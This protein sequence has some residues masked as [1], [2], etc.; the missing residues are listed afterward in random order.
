MKIYK[1]YIIAIFLSFWIQATLF[2]E[3]AGHGKHPRKSEFIY[4]DSKKLDWNDFRKSPPNG[5]AYAAMTSSAIDMQ[6]EGEGNT[7]YFTINAVF[8]PGDSW[9]VPEVTA[10]ILKHEQ[11]HFDITEIWARMLRKKISSHKFKNVKSISSEVQNM[12]NWSVSKWKKM[13]TKYDHLTQH[14]IKE[15]K[16][17]KWNE[18]IRKVLVKLRPYQQS[19][20]KITLNNIK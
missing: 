7:L 11:G 18:K 6:F 13:Q 15:S 1:R 3:S 20:I 17:N 10:Y 14:S 12:Y 8:D 5:S 4:W 19:E 2:A 16:Q 9:K